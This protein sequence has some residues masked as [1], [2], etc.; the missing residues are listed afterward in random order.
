LIKIIVFFL[1]PIILFSQ[2]IKGKIYDS[3][4][5]AKGIKVYNISKEIKTYTDD[6]GD[7]QILASINDTLY[8][9]SLF[10]Q[11]KSVKVKS[12]YFN[13]IIV[14][15]LKKVINELG[16][17]LLED[18]KQDKFNSESQSDDLGQQLANAI[19]NNPPLYTPQSQY[20][21]GANIFNLV[22]MVFKLF[23]RKKKNKIKPIEYIK[24]KDLDSLFK[25]D[26]L[27]NLK[28]I[29]QDL[30]I[31]S[32]YANLFL[33]YCEEKYLNKTLILE[34]NKVILLDSMFKFGEEF[35]K[36]TMAY[37]ASVDSLKS[38]K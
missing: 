32:Q 20:A 13:E 26:N 30:K 29:N 4:S 9:E 3:E 5:T 18:N 15:E 7:F 24:Y 31:E 2:E 21:N 33:D 38:K 14:F 36:I 28:L 19:K 37:K 34:K 11:P 17:F 8:F 12:S 27:F 6:N 1:C 22:G 16:E 35:L 25:N 10:H 23:K